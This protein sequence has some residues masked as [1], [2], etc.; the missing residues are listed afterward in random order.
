MSKLINSTSWIGKKTVSTGIWLTQCTQ[1]TLYSI[2]YGH[3][4]YFNCNLILISSRKSDLTSKYIIS[5]ISWTWFSCIVWDWI[6][7]MENEE[8]N[9]K[10][11]EIHVYSLIYIR[12]C[13][14]YELWSDEYSWW[15]YF[16]GTLLLF[17]ALNS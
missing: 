17:R 13:S 15:E 9:V 11:V 3:D 12:L 8:S 14:R 1:C 6:W 2:Q 16:L 10:L 5:L 4:E 7:E